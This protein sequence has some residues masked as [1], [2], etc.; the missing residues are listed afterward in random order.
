[1]QENPWLV[2][3]K[4]GAEK[5]RRQAKVE[6][7]TLGCGPEALVKCASQ[8]LVQEG[9]EVKEIKARKSTQWE[10]KAAL[11]AARVAAAKCDADLLSWEE[12]YPEL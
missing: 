5:Q 1:M 8:Q 2:K 10:Q 6:S 11:K 3:A 12:L 7:S 9:V 4:K